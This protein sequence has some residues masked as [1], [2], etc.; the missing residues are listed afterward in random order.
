MERIKKRIINEKVG[1]LKLSDFK[2]GEKVE[3]I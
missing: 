2:H 3:R 1:V